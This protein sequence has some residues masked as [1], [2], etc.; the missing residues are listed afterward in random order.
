MKKIK[1]YLL[2]AIFGIMFSNINA[3]SILLGPEPFNSN[4]YAGNCPDPCTYWMSLSSDFP[5][6]WFNKQGCFGPYVG[7][8]GTWTNFYGSLLRTP[9]VSC[10]G[11]K[12]VILTLIVSNSYDKDHTQ[13]YIDFT[14]YD[15]SKNDYQYADSIWIDNKK[16]TS[17]QY[18]Y[19]DK[20][21]NCDTVCVFFTMPSYPSSTTAYFY[22]GAKN[23]YNDATTFSYAFDN[24]EVSDYLVTGV[25]NNIT[26]NNDFTISNKSQNI[27]TITTIGY[28]KISEV[29]LINIEGK[30]LL[31]ETIPA[32]STKELNISDIPKGIYFIRLL[33]DDRLMTKK[34]IVY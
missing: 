15:N 12:K 34:V 29:S 17:N 7:Y 23:S 21:R 8:I 32:N 13:N 30:L 10:Y 5:V 28:S 27:Y 24:V 9:V 2:I 20:L 25:I 3:Q 19:F 11:L 1:L 33:S 31:K 16:I 14:M 22:M 18:I 26:N 6:Q 4:I